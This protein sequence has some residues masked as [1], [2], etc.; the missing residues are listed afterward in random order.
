MC[1]KKKD[2]SE[3]ETLDAKIS[4]KAELTGVNQVVID[5]HL[6][7]EDYNPS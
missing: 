1:L 7:T 3:S 4:K 5:A 2:I 6:A